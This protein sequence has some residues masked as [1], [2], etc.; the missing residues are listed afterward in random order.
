MINLNLFPNSVV[1]WI[2][3][4]AALI[5]IAFV[6]FIGRRITRSRRL[7]DQ[8]PPVQSAAASS[9][10]KSE[11]GTMPQNDLS[12]KVSKPI[13]AVFIWFAVCS[14]SFSLIFWAAVVMKFMTALVMV[15]LAGGVIYLADKYSNQSRFK[16]AAIV[17]FVEVVVGFAGYFT[18]TFDYFFAV[19]DDWSSKLRILAVFVFVVSAGILIAHWQGWTTK[20]VEKTIV[21][22]ID[23]FSKLNVRTLWNKLTPVEQSAVR[24]KLGKGDHDKSRWREA[25]LQ[26]LEK[27]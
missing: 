19:A 4:F 8:N 14:M 3:F 23:D 6:V 7:R 16:T 10:S 24:S 15:A 12:A 11:E 9:D 18:G 27:R 20:R 17:L 13:P 26:V 22:S 25:I 21:K 5:I 2:Y 1:G